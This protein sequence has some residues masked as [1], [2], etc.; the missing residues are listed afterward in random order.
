MAGHIISR[1]RCSRKSHHG[2]T[3]AAHKVTIL[4]KTPC[5][6]SPP[7]YDI[8]VKTRRSIRERK[9]PDVAGIDEMSDQDLVR[10]TLQG[11]SDCYRPLVARYQG[12]V[13]G[14]AYSLVANWTDAQDI[15]QETFIRAYSNLDQLRDGSK[16]AAWLRRVTFGVAMDWLRTFRPKLFAQIDGNVDLEK[17]EIPDFAP[18]PA[19]VAERREL[20]DAVLRARRLPAAQ[21]SRAAD[22]VSLGRA[23]I[24]KGGRLPGYSAGDGQVDHSPGAREA[25]GGDGR[26]LGRE[27]DKYHG[28]RRCLTNISCRPISQR[29]SMPRLA[30][31]GRA[32]HLTSLR[33]RVNESRKRPLWM[34][35]GPSWAR[36]RHGLRTFAPRCRIG[37]ANRAPIGGC[38][39]WKTFCVLSR[40]DSPRRA[41]SSR[42]HRRRGSC[43]W[44]LG[45]AAM[46]PATLWMRAERRAAAVERWI[47][48]AKPQ[49]DEL[50]QQVSR[51]LG[52]PTDAKREAATVLRRG[53]PGEVLRIRQ[54]ASQAS[55][56]HGST[57]ARQV[58]R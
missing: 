53:G 31:G 2:S 58:G 25:E 21:V 57:V 7:H 29:S 34:R 24:S 32:W 51:W 40:P 26:C 44:P 5:N 15:A 27:G 11:Q 56:G 47:E 18:G 14:L 9:E 35:C 45:A 8:A 19:E 48:Q 6:R 10:L 20:A 49:D 16:F 13:Y 33:L 38:R 39:G 36:S 17:L 52:S 41:E 1:H 30:D 3:C 23:F 55:L 12:H 50:D 22:D 28:A 42:S 54:R 46:F 4:L 37:A 43:Q